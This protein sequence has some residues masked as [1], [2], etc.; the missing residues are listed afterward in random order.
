MDNAAKAPL[1]EVPD[2]GDSLDP[3]SVMERTLRRAADEA[4]ADLVV[5]LRRED[6][7]LVQGGGFDGG[8][9]TGP[10]QPTPLAEDQAS[11]LA[12]ELGEPVLRSPEPLSAGAG[13]R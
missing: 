1:G 2:V 11:G 8:S 5:L 12:R 3:A 7:K 4:E 6:D 13:P 9:L 10:L